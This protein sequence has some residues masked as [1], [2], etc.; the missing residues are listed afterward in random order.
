M[1]KLKLMFLTNS[2]IRFLLIGGNK[3]E[4]CPLDFSESCQ[5]FI[6]TWNNSIV[7]KINT[8]L[9]GQNITLEK[10]ITFIDPLEWIVNRFNYFN[11]LKTLF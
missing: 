2:K 11:L 10:N 6:K 5:W 3:F 8:Y 9:K 7:P 4:S 1:I